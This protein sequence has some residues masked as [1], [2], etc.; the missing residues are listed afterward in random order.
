VSTHTWRSVLF[1]DRDAF[2]NF[3][4]LEPTHASR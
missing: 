1:E 3:N 4:S 2:V